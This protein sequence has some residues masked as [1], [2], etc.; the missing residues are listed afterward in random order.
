[1]LCRWCEITISAEGGAAAPS[2]PA[3]F[4]AP[5]TISGP[6]S[7]YYSTY[8]GSYEPQ[9]QGGGCMGYYTDESQAV[10]TIPGLPAGT[11]TVSVT[12]GSWGYADKTYIAWDSP[13][14]TSNYLTNPS[15]TCG[16]SACDSN[17]GST[18]DY[19]AELSAGSHDLYIGSASDGNYYT[20]LCASPPFCAAHASS[21]A[22]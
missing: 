2:P 7:P 20:V 19:E 5:I 17:E 11:I 16:A 8:Y 9:D 13:A 21:A 1:M 3:S 12:W 10:Y 4:F 6:S 22:C 15:A 18:L 14:S